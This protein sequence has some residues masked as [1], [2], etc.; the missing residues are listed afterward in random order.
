MT[1]RKE[2]L[3]ADKIGKTGKDPLDPLKDGLDRLE[4]VN[5]GEITDK[6]LDSVAGGLEGYDTQK[7]LAAEG[8]NSSWCC[9]NS[10]N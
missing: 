4:E 8:C 9:S 6:D 7:G 5:I 10:G 2:Q 1:N 3:M